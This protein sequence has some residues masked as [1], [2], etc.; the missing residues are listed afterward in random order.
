[1]RRIVCVVLS[2]VIA[3]FTIGCSESESSKEKSKFD[4]MV[5]VL[6][7]MNAIG[8]DEAGYNRSVRGVSREVSPEESNEQEIIETSEQKSKQKNLVIL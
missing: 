2:L 3:T 4:V 5:D 1:M 6:N 7:A 8:E